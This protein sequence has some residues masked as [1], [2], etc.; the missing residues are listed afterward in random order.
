MLDLLVQSWL[1]VTLALLLLLV[2]VMAFQLLVVHVRRALVRLRRP[3]GGRPHEALG[4]Q[5]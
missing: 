5:R 3:L 1:M 4:L 2:V